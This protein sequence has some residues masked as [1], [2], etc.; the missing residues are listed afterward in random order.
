MTTSDSEDDDVSISTPVGTPT[1]LSGVDISIS[2]ESSPQIDQNEGSVSF[3]ADSESIPRSL[4]FL[5]TLY[6]QSN[7]IEQQ[8]ASFLLQSSSF[9]FHAM[10]LLTQVKNRL[11]HSSIGTQLIRNDSAITLVVQKLCDQ[12]GYLKRVVIKVLDIL[13]PL[14]QTVEPLVERCRVV[15]IPYKRCILCNSS[16]GLTSSK[17][18]L[19]TCEGPVSADYF[20]GYCP[21]KRCSAGSYQVDRYVSKEFE[22]DGVVK[23]LYKYSFVSPCIHL[24]DLRNSLTGTSTT[25]FPR[26]KLPDTSQLMKMYWR[27]GSFWNCGLV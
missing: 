3:N 20:W 12:F 7:A 18:L 6:A 5:H 27:T 23:K 4:D 19:L 9:I 22:E 15:E 8:P 13:A 17:K 26:S 14:A 1:G 24:I 10:S 16:L 11:Q 21:R 25:M 2:D